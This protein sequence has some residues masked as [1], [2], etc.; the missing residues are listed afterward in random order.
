MHYPIRRSSHNDWGIFQLWLNWLL[1]S[2]ALTLLIVVSLWVKPLYMPFVAFGLQFVL[3]ALIRRNR[4]TRV[5]SCYILPF[6]VSRILFWSGVVM[7]MVNMLYSKPLIESVFNP[8]AVNPEIPFIVVL[9][10]MPI[11]VLLTG[12]AYLH[13]SS[14][15]FCRDCKLRHGTPAER[16]FLGIIYTQVGQYQV[17]MLFWI[18]LISGIISWSYYLVNYDNSFLNLPDR[19]FFFLLP[20]LIW[21]ASAL[22]LAARYLGIWGYYRQNVEGSIERH[23]ASTQLRFIMIWNDRIALRVPETDTDRKISLD[24]KFDIPV[25]AFVHKTEGLSLTM[26]IQYFKNLSGM[27]DAEV[28]LMYTNIQGNADCN[29]FHYLVFVTDEEK[30]RF[31]ESHPNCRW[32][33]LPR[34]ADL[35]NAHLVEPL[36]AAEMVRLHTITVTAKTYDSTGRRRYKVRHYKPSFNLAEI[37]SL[38]IDYNDSDWLY[39]ADNNQDTSFYHTR[40]FWRKYINGIGR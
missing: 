16:G 27:S 37:R 14:L 32:L 11:S 20:T 35:I 1:G 22:Y 7:I 19:F 9:I 17:G 24:E 31:D 30:Q 39:I 15:S 6:I 4:E 23:G 5:P 28:R 12:W 34:I 40:R 8:E 25:S 26:A 29:I 3:F 13:R 2:G 10:V 33:T 36:L 18:S 38:D 21:I